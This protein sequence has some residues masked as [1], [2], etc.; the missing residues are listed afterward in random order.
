MRATRN[1]NAPHPPPTHLFS[2]QFYPPLPYTR[3]L[4]FSDEHQCSEVQISDFPAHYV[5]RTAAWGWVIFNSLIYFVSVDTAWEGSR[6]EAEARG[7]AEGREV[8]PEAFL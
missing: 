8:I 3:P 6:A 1:A 2:L 4:G 5:A 7:L